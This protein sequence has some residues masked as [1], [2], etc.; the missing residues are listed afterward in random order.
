MSKFRIGPVPAGVSRFHC[1]AIS[2]AAAGVPRRPL[3]EPLEGRRLLSAVMYAGA[4]TGKIVYLNGGHG[5]ACD[6]AS[7]WVT[8]RPETNE[9]VEDFGNQDQLAPYAD[10]LLRAG[11]TVVPMRPIGHQTNEVVLDN[12][13]AGVTYAGAWSNSTVTS[14]YYG[15]AGQVPYRLASVAATE[16]AVA[17]YAPSL[18][19]AGFYPVYAWT[20]DGTDRSG[21]QLYRVNYAGGSAEVRVDHRVVGKGWVYL[22]TYYFGAGAGG[23]S[24][25]ISNQSGKGSGVVIADAVRFGNGMGTVKRNN[26]VSG[27]SREDEASLYWL[28][29]ET[30][31]GQSFSTFRGGST[32]DSDANVGAPARYAAYMN[33]AAFGQSV[34][35]GFHTN[36]AGADGTTRGTYGLYNSAA[37]ATPNQQRWAFLAANEVNDDLVAAGTP[38]LEYAWFNK[39]DSALT[40]DRSDIDFGEIRASATGNEFD[41]T[42]LEVA[43][44]DNAQDAALLRAPDVRDRVGRSSY[45]ATVRYFGEFGGL[46]NLT[47]AP[48]APTDLRTTTAAGGDVTLAWAAPPTGQANGDAAT[49]YVIYASRNGYGFDVLGTVAGG[50]TTTYTI[51][52]AQLDGGAYYY[53]VAAANVGGESAASVVVGARKSP[54]GPANRVLIVNGFDRF[55]RTQDARQSV[56]LSTASGS[57]TAVVDR[58]WPRVGNSF[59]YVVQAGQAIAAYAAAA[60][61]FDSAQSNDV[62]AGRVDLSRYHTVVWLSGEESTTD[63]TFSAA[64]QSVVAAYVASGGRLFTSGSEIGWDLDRPSGPTTADRSFYNA[65][66]KADYA[67]DD[68]GTYLVTAPAAGGTSIFAGLA[69]FGFDNGSLSYDVD[70]PDVLATTGGSTAALSYSGGTGGVAAVQY[71]AAGANAARVV[72]FGFP[73]EAITTPAARAGVMTRVLDFFQTGVTPAA[74]AT[75]TVNDGSVQR[76]MVRSWTITFDKPVV[77]DA[78]A[79]TLVGRNGAGAGMTASNANPAGDGRTWVLSW[80]GVSLADGVYDL[81]VVANKVHAATANGPTMSANKV[82]T[83]HRLFG[84]SNGD[85]YVSSFDASVLKQTYDKS[86]GEAEFDPAFDYDSD[87]VI[88]AYDSLQFKRRYFVQLTY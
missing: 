34:Y 77:L 78:G 19:T 42:I 64:E 13:S 73:F 24:V 61:G 70:F 25:Q 20:R 14:G 69:G 72:T 81:T 40:L 5:F 47:M 33:G 23:G 32:L 39:A 80:G 21:D 75:S 67:A 38:T 45:Q 30:A 55:D 41:A 83:S 66:L 9:V 50:G 63:E 62:A 59:D 54:A 74:V 15:T 76:S 16:T 26:A 22:G 4:L 60:I 87:G 88:T 68:A 44:H 46:T 37:N 18:P 82:Y 51:P 71:A 1:A 48:V 85:K 36:A 11:A 86:A 57:A 8:G 65:T 84:D 17:T 29:A 43:F 53:K 79:L 49:R 2:A 12:T 27:R 52:A 3:V 6:G 28:E 35:L 56:A 7:A 58:V 10:S 31:V